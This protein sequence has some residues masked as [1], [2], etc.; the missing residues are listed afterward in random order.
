M[1]LID[2]GIP[3][4]R[5]HRHAAMLSARQSWMLFLILPVPLAAIPFHRTAIVHRAG[6]PETRARRDLG[7]LIAA[8]RRAHG[9]VL[10]IVSEEEFRT[11]AP[12]PSVRKTSSPA[13]SQVCGAEG[14]SR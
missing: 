5:R 2:N 1:E 10:A 11:R 7:S 14:G 13:G 3:A 6:F 4:R 9:R 8:G 12:A